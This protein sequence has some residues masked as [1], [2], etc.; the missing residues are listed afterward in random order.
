M[1]FTN[2][3]FTNM[4]ITNLTITN[5]TLTNMTILFQI[6]IM[7]LENYENSQ[8]NKLIILKSK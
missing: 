3:T 6:F 2:M 4:T 7:I 8:K 1:T 5:I